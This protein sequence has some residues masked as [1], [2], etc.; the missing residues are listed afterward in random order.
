MGREWKLG[1]ISLHNSQRQ[2][3][4]TKKWTLRTQVEW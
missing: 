1:S 2:S 3:W 4:I